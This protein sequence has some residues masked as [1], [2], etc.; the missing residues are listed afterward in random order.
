MLKRGEFLIKKIESNCPIA[1]I[2]TTW[3]PQ[4]GC[5]SA[6]ERQL[7]GVHPTDMGRESLYL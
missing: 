5:N 1:H 7:V 3:D 2:L 6:T 4:R